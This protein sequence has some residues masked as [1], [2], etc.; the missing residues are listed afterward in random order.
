MSY[1]LNKVC[2]VL[3]VKDFNLTYFYLITNDGPLWFGN[4]PSIYTLQNNPRRR[5]VGRHKSPRLL[6]PQA[7]VSDFLR[8]GGLKGNDQKKYT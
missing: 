3:D 4:R 6:A 7:G 2:I 5:S 1:Q 8:G